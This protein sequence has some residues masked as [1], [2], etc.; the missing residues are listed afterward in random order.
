M[1]GCFGSFVILVGL[2]R[3]AL[4]FIFEDIGRN[5]HLEFANLD[6]EPELLAHNGR[7]EA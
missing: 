2:A 7:D 4:Q 3:G 5:E 6:R 1:E